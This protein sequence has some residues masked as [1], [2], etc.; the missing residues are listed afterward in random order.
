MNYNPVQINVSLFACIAH[1]G[2]TSIQDV[3]AEVF[4]TL[5]VTILYLQIIDPFAHFDCRLMSDSRQ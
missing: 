4:V 1:L 3:I 2:Y 5:I